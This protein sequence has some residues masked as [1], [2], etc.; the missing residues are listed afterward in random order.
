M[1][2]PIW[3]DFGKAL[4]IVGPSSRRVLAGLF[5]MMVVGS[6]L[7]VMGIGLVLPVMTILISPGAVAEYEP[8]RRFSEFL[9]DPTASNLSL[10][11]L[12]CLAAAYVLKNFYRVALVYTQAWFSFRQQAE[13]AQRLYRA[14]LLKPYAF[15][16][17]R[18]SAELIRNITTESD[19]FSLLVLMPALLICAEAIVLLT[20]FSFLLFVNFGVTLAVV[21]VFGSSSVV[22]YMLVQHRLIRWGRAR[23]HH[24]M[25]R[26]KQAQQGLGGIK[27]VKVLGREDFFHAAFAEHAT[28]RS[29]Y[30]GRSFFL[31]QMPVV[32][33]ETVAVVTVVVLFAV[34]VLNGAVFKES[35]PTLA[36]FGAAALRTM[37]SLNKIL[38]AGQ[39]LRYCRPVI[40]TLYAELVGAELYQRHS[41]DFDTIHDRF[42]RL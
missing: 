17:Q 1:R 40:D 21:A 8:L 5:G 3:R 25:Q 11:L 31:G 35:V 6:I 42:E 7:E 36:L 26:L 20:I 15:H 33:L 34:L 24:D 22:F 16:L 13:I 29:R 19:L 27:D 10:V 28:G 18:N 14:Y 2:N 23:Q 38:G 41:S 39:Q 37:P 9:G 30:E 32:W 4:A 12:G